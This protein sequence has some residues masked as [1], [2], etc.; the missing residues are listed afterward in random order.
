MQLCDFWNN[1]D[2]LLHDDIRRIPAFLIHQ[3]LEGM[4][5]EQ[6]DRKWDFRSQSHYGGLCKDFGSLKIMPCQL[7]LALVSP[8]VRIDITRMASE[9]IGRS[10]VCGAG[11]DRR[12]GWQ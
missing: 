12:A 7:R 9:I 6:G 8:D 3:L 4:T 10:L 1:H 11:V 2:L 5:E